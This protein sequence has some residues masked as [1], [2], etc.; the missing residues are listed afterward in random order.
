[1]KKN[2][3]YKPQQKAQAVLQ[4]LS[5][6][7]SAA[8]ICRDLNINENLLSRW[9]QQLLTHAALVFERDHE[10]TE[11]DEQISEL[12]RLVGRLTME[13]EVAKKPH[14][15]R[16]IKPAK[17]GGDCDAINRLPGANPLRGH[18]LSAQFLL[19]PRG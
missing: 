12:Q 7:K 8:Q 1:M 18:R 16:F 14:S 11:K 9:K 5:G 19:L 15:L 2:R 10:A 4:V 6:S 13:L 3:I 17:T